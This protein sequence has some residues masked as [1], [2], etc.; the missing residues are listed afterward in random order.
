VQEEYREKGIGNDLLD[1]AVLKIKT[2]EPHNVYLGLM[3]QVCK[4][5]PPSSEGAVALWDS[6]LVRSKEASIEGLLI[7]SIG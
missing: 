3:G 1:Q 2:L 5:K 6:Y 7:I 4:E